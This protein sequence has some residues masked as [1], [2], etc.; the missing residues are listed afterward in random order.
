MMIGMM[1]AIPGTRTRMGIMTST[2]IITGT[3][4]ILTVTATLT[5]IGT[6]TGA[7]VSFMEIR[8]G[9]PGFSS[10]TLIQRIAM[11]M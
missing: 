1:I 4:R 3:I 9:I 2:L 6:K 7:A 10:G 11:V 8:T 5:W